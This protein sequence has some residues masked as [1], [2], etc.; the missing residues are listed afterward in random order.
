MIFFRFYY[1][2]EKNK[3]QNSKFI[4]YYNDNRKFWIKK[5]L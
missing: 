5:G 4:A 2:F 3:Q 1:S